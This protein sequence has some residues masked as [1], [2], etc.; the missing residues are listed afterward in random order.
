MKTSSFIRYALSEPKSVPAMAFIVS[1]LP[2]VLAAILSFHLAIA[3][4]IATTGDSMKPYALP[5]ALPLTVALCGIIGVAGMLLTLRWLYVLGNGRLMR[6]QTWR[7]HLCRLLSFVAFVS[8]GLTLL[9]INDEYTVGLQVIWF[10]IVLA[11]LVSSISLSWSYPSVAPWTYGAF[12]SFGAFAFYV[13]AA[14]LL[15]LGEAW[16]DLVIFMGM[17][18]PVIFV[19]GYVYMRVAI[20]RRKKNAELHAT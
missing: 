7:I 5:Y 4:N 15:I 1:A 20:T 6:P 12:L 9:D 18:Y 14:P 11:L 10:T 13:F 19:F 16:F 3:F 17:V 2:A 8:M